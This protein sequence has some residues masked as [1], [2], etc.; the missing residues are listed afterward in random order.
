MAF[1]ITFINSE[2]WFLILKK[3]IEMKSEIENNL[4]IWKVVRTILTKKE[5]KWLW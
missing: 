5:I 3:F 1:M 2:V 4:I